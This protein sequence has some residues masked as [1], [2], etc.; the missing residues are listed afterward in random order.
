MREIKRL[1]VLTLVEHGNLRRVEAAKE[2]KI[3]ERQFYRI[4]KTYREKGE[5]G[6]IHG[7]CRKPSHRRISKGVRDKIKTLLEEKYS[8]Y[9]TLHFQEILSKTYGVEISYSTL[10]SIRRKAKHPTPRAKKAQKHRG[11]RP[12]LPFYG[13]MLQADASIH[14]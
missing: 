6:L 2:L 13:M 9:N 14:P 11:R 5:Q 1:K 3:S 4:Q 8:D 7:N 10:Q 12:R